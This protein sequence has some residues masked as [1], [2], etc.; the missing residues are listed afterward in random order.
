MRNNLLRFV[1][2]YLVWAVIVVAIFIY[3]LNNLIQTANRAPFGADITGAFFVPFAVMFGGLGIPWILFGIL[4]SRK[5]GWTKEVLAD[6]RQAPATVLS[7]SDTGISQG[8]STFFVTLRLQ[9]QPADD[10]PFEANLE[11]RV[12]RVDV[13][14][15]GDTFLVK[16]DPDNKAHILLLRQSD[17]DAAYGMMPSSGTDIVQEL[18]KL[19]E[20]HKNGDISDTEY[21]AAKKKLLASSN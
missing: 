10:V 20:L 7:I 19:A 5:P 15:I 6:G 4:M 14:R 9:V 11:T 16:Y 12:S 1:A 13:P 21:D 18:A 2:F 8:R 3:T 17:S